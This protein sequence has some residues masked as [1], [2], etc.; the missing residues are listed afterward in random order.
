MMKTALFFAPHSHIWL[1]AYPEALVAEALAQHNVKIHYVTC[2]KALASWCV[3]MEAVGE[4]ESATESA[5]DAI[6]AKCVQNKDVLLKHF[7][8][9]HSS[10]NSYLSDK[11]QKRI[12][13]ILESVSQNQVFDFQ[14][15]G[16][17][18]G[19]AALYNLILNRKKNFELG[20]TN[21]EWHAF[22]KHF[23]SSLVSFFAGKNLLVQQ[24]PD[25]VIFY[26]SSYSINLVVRLQA[27][28]LRIPCFSIYAGSNWAN[29][30]KKIHIST[31]DSFDATK[32]RLDLWQR[33]YHA[34]PATIES[35]QSTLLFQKALLG[36]TNSMVYGGGNK[37]VYAEEV[38][39]KWG[40]PSQKKILLMATSSSDELLAAQ[41]IKA[42]P[43]NLIMAFRNQIDWIAETIKFVSLRDDLVLVIRIHPRELPNRREPIA[44]EHSIRLQKLL[45]DVP[46]NVRVNWPD[47][48]M[49]LYDWL[50]AVD[51]GLTSWSSSGKEFALWGIP[52]LSYTN[53]ISFYPKQELGFVGETREEYFRQIDAALKQGWSEQRIYRAYRWVAYDLEAPVFDLSD[54]IPD[55][56]AVR[57]SLFWR[58]FDKLTRYGF[59]ERKWLLYHRRPLKQSGLI[60]NRVLTD[61][62]TEDVLEETRV[63]L[64]PDDE[65]REIKNIVS[66]MANL[67]FGR[68][69]QKTAP[70]SPLRV[71][72]A[73]MLEQ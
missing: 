11:D 46:S 8:F 40:I 42:I 28:R 63:R 21:E 22:L 13:S 73:A 9:E 29:R 51:L 54:A 2:D 69:W 45:Q 53:E 37:R 72:L 44:S 34:L 10:L 17:D 71:N 48:G 12:S 50:D 23:R 47:D 66:E 24:K 1:H 7:A 39:Q 65:I 35:L 41:T 18:V 38:R 25:F 56:L 19:R 61:I 36:G 26:S 62:P 6:C 68:N 3:A 70:L 60:A 55:S 43:S 30:L 64:K 32:M 16:L 67:R 4:T 57:K 58:I 49:S 59:A 14:I 15:D 31:T 27:E 20:F 33:T 52:N 5:K